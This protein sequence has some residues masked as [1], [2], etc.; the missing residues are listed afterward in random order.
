MT[1][2]PSGTRLTGECVGASIVVLAVVVVLVQVMSVAAGTVGRAVV[3]RTRAQIAADAVAL[4]GVT[5]EAL[6]ERVA[7]ANGGRIVALERRGGPLDR[8]V[9]ATVAVG[10][11]T[12]IARATLAP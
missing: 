8:T 10:R 12:G 4:A 3:D 9:D 11:A 7:A 1:D 6:A 5:D 2:R